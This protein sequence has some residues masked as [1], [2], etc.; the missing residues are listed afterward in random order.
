MSEKLKSCPFCD[1][2]IKI[3]FAGGGW[4]WLHKLEEPYPSCPITHSRKY[5]THEQCEK[6]WNTRKGN[7]K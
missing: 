7:K 6:A 2:E 5:A 3:V 4:F 1:R